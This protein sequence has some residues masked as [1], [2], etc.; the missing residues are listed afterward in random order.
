MLVLLVALSYSSKTEKAVLPDEFKSFHLEVANRLANFKSEENTKFLA[1]FAD[2]WQSPTLNTDQRRA[3]MST[4]AQFESRNLSASPY[5][6]TYLESMMVFFD[7]T[8]SVKGFEAWNKGVNTLLARKGFPKDIILSI[9]DSP[10]GITKKKAFFATSY[11]RWCL[12]DRVITYKFDTTLYIKVANSR[13]SYISELDTVSIEGTSGTIL[14]FTCRYIGSGGQVFWKKAGF[15][16]AKVFAS[17]KRYQLNFLKS[18]QNFDSVSFHFTDLLKDPLLG[19]LIL[20]PNS[21]SRKELVYYPHFFSYN[22]NISITNLFD[23]VDYKGGISI[24]GHLLLGYGSKQEPA[25]IT[26]IK[27]RRPFIT[28]LSPTF[29]IR[30]DGFST[31]GASITIRLLKDSIVHNNK[32]VDF[33]N[34]KRQLSLATDFQNMLTKAPYLD[35]YHQIGIYSEQLFWNMKRDDLIFNTPQGSSGSEAIF[36]SVNFFNQDM[37]DGL[38]RR[39]DQHPITLIRR[40]ERAQKKKGPLTCDGFSR[41]VRRSNSES[42][43]LLKEM[44]FLGYIVYDSESRVFSTTPK[45]HE[46]IKAR[47]GAQDYDAILFNSQDVRNGNH[48]V[49]DLGTFN[50][51]IFGIP[52]INLSDTQN[53]KV[54]PKNNS[55]VLKKNRDME[56]NGE[57]RAGLVSFK[58]DGFKFDYDSFSINFD[59]VVSMNLDYR[60]QKMDNAGNRV[61]SSLSSTIE[62]IQGTLQ[63]DEPNNKS[64]LKRRPGYPKFK[65]RK[66]SYIYYDAPSIFGGIYKRSN[67][68]FKVYPYELDS[69]NSF[70]KSSLNFKG[71]L[72]SAGIFAPFEET[73]LV[74]PDQSLGFTRKLDSTGVAIYQNKGQFY[75]T[76]KLSNEGLKGK[77]SIKY[78]TS[79]SNSE[80]FFLF[81]DSCGSYLKSMT[82][83]RQLAGVEFPNGNAGQRIMKWQPYR[84]KMDF[85]KDETP[86]NLYDNQVKLNGNMV[87]KPAGLTG[88]GILDV[89]TAT[90]ASPRFDMAA[91][92]F[93]GDPSNVSIYDGTRES[94]LFV[95]DSLT[96]HIDLKSYTGKFDKK[97]GV[98]KSFYPDLA[99]LSYSNRIGW[100]MG[101]QQLTIAASDNLTMPESIVS[102]YALAYEGKVPKGSV[103]VSTKRDQDSLCFASPVALYSMNSKTLTAGKVQH[104]LIAD[105][106]LILNPKRDTV[107]LRSNAGMDKLYH[108][109]LYANRQSKSHHFYDVDISVGGRNGFNGQ[110]HYSY[111]DKY[112]KIDTITFS[113]ITVDR[114]Y[115]TTAFAS[116]MDEDSFFLSPYF[117]FKGKVT[118]F[119]DLKHLTFDGGARF[120]H[121]Y[122]SLAKNWI[123]FTAEIAPDSVMIP[124]NLPYQTVD[125]VKVYAGTYL[126]RDS[127]SVYPTFFTGRKYAEDS[128]F[129]QPQGYLYYNDNGSYYQ[130]SA[131]DKIRKPDTAGDMVSLYSDF[132]LLINE[133]KLKL[134]PDLGVAKLTSAGKAINNIATKDLVFNGMLTF[135]FLF[136]TD[137]MN[138]L[139]ADVLTSSTNTIDYTKPSVTA[140]LRELLGNKQSAAL[141]ASYAKTPILEKIPPEYLHTLTVTDI[142]LR[143]NKKSRSYISTGEIG[144]ANIGS[145]QVNRKVKGFIELMPNSEHRMYVYLDLG[146]NQFYTF[147]YTS[148]GNMFASSTNVS[149]NQYIAKTSNKK[150]SIKQGLWLTSYSYNNADDALVDKVTARYNQVKAM[151]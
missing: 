103:F 125:K 113:T 145:K 11:I 150:R 4:T 36:E 136:H 14:P 118:A 41:F 97:D 111:I 130:L 106:A 17:L 69:L 76:I 79:M 26:F 142:Q 28:A 71:E 31:N 115:K 57:V 147:I 34:T 19:N 61:L 15:D 75:N 131:I 22:K 42:E 82:I 37:Y 1:T 143:W 83:D 85:F 65:S 96:T 91:Y 105:A 20:S 78:L 66:D 35:S 86:F 98:F 77:G 117:K 52:Q 135:D 13:L 44:G 84:D 92:T 5:L 108:A 94:K 10:V 49:L 2:F 93:T 81:P 139:A 149:F 46:A 112:G 23:S 126:R 45:L 129:I 30:N 64:G 116:I 59:K 100:N 144:V 124:I 33:D 137:A 68:Y 51:T 58:G 55:I 140:A 122:E 119:S 60:S 146:N 40:Y 56:F 90:I 24:K 72:T 121:K 47:N 50:L 102:S 53:V 80:L 38:M 138:L 148:A 6:I 133:G 109:D 73:L 110:G 25:R 29:I 128:A 43:I 16:T 63:I 120:T 134:G 89:N 27:T 18:K 32:Q 87:L 107:T 39:D 104:M 70:E 95:S 54:Y 127:I 8:S 9:F 151:K 99:Y 3:I 101:N 74:Q 21:V 114:S 7:S 141:L 123:R 48:A 132:D 67:F 12:S 62:N 88:A